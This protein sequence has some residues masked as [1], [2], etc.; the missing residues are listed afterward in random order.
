M[1]GPI[2]IDVAF[3]EVEAYEKKEKFKKKM[4]GVVMLE[5]LELTGRG[6]RN[7][8]SLFSLLL[9][10]PDFPPMHQIRRKIESNAG[11]NISITHGLLQLTE[12]EG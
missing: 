1:T 10:D 3:C 6:S 2:E 8:H 12:R 4:K 5:H 9:Q 7:I 11:R